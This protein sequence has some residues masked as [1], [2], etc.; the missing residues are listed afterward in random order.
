MHTSRF[1]VMGDRSEFQACNIQILYLLHDLFEYHL[2]GKN[3]I[4]G[5]NF[6]NSNTAEILHG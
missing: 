5:D 3:L 2:P 1:E 4:S 6:H